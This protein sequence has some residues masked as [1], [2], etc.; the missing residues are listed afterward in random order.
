VHRSEEASRMAWTPFL[1]FSVL[2]SRSASARELDLDHLAQYHD[3]CAKSDAR[4]THLEAVVC[5]SLQPGACG[6]N[7]TAEGDWP[8]QVQY[9]HNLLAAL[10]SSD[11]CLNTTRARSVV[12]WLNVTNPSDSVWWWTWLIFQPEYYEMPRKA[13]ERIES[14]ATLGRKCWAFA[15]LAQLWPPLRP[16]LELAVA[17]A[18]LTLHSFITAYDSA[19]PM[20]MS[21]CPRV[22]ANCYQNASYDPSR[23]GTCPERVRE[24][25]VGFEWENKGGG[26]GLVP[27]QPVHYPF[28]RYDQTATFRADVAS[29]VGTVLNYI[30]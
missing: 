14:P 4:L 3:P 20:S 6:T 12:S 21:L 13:G 10:V 18:G 8:N 30:I 1:L 26:R 16:R 9:F 17:S 2:G 27:Q 7:I 24:F 15:Y 28:P 29:A 5:Q 11:T 19:V 23:N 25:Y 22:S